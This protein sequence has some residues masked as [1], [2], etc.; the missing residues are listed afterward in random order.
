M[1]GWRLVFYVWDRLAFVAVGAFIIE[2]CWRSNGM[3]L[4]D[5]SD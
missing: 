4:S 5:T 2:K 3:K 1:M